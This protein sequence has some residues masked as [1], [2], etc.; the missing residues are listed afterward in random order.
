MA[1]DRFG[2]ESRPSSHGI[3][4]TSSP[5]PFQLIKGEESSWENLVGKFLSFVAWSFWSLYVGFEIFF[6]KIDC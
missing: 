5:Y 1:S 6:V 4:L 2:S 3:I